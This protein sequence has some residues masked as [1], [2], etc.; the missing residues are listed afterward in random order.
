MPADGSSA[1]YI[2]QAPMLDIM[3][4]QLHYLAAHVGPECAPECSDCA[5]LELVEDWLLQPFR[6]SIEHAPDLADSHGS[7]T[8]TSRQSPV[9]RT[10]WLPWA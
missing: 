3:I 8:G 5:R 6:S 4:E 9:T 2:R 7:P 10:S 1:R